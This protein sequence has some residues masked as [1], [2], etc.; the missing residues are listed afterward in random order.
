MAYFNGTAGAN[1]IAIRRIFDQTTF[2][3]LPE[4]IRRS[5]VQLE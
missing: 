3:A 4:H 5:D 1:E 2:Q